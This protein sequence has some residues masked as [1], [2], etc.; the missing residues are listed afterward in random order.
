MS[1]TVIH[2]PGT[3]LAT[4]QLSFFTVSEFFFASRKV[5]LNPFEVG[6]LRGGADKD[7]GD[8]EGPT[9]L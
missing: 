6:K 2:I 4:S 9:A 1:P 3:C 7:C 5:V 8:D